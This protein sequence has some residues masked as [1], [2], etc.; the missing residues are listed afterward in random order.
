MR[1]RPNSHRG[2]ALLLVLWAITVLSFSVLW[3]SNLVNVELQSGAADAKGL[4]ARLIAL[5]G[6]ALGLHPSVTREDTELLNRDV[7]PG[8]RMNVRIRGEGAR[9]NINALL[10]QQDRATMQSLFMLW[11][12]DNQQA[13]SLI[14]R[15]ID[16]VDDDIGRQMN[17][18]E[19]A[20]Y[21]A[22]GLVEGPANRPF[23][24]VA[25]MS[26][27]LGWELVEEANPGWH[28]A[29]TIFGTGQVDVNEASAEILEAVTGL[30]PEMVGEILRLRQGADGVE[31]SEDD[32][33][34]EKVD[35]LRGWLQASI[36]PYDQV[37]A[38]LTTESAVKRIDSKGA[39]GDREVSISVVAES[40]SDGGTPTYLLWEEH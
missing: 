24:S 20:D 13:D 33:R 38:K 4:R 36:R 23:R 39:V 15:L 3:V 2:A 5:S 16:Y 31:P 9:L 11:G 35:Q 1:S 10:A 30:P 14:D 7:G 25:E 40:P 8:E 12:L 27:V 32:L 21:Q 18:A 22:V 29:F 26:R 34:F 19:L 17:G 37:A 6:V 28:E